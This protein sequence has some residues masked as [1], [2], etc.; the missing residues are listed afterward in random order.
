MTGPSYHPEIA[1]DTNIGIPDALPNNVFAREAWKKHYPLILSGLMLLIMMVSGCSREEPEVD[2]EAEGIVAKVG[3]FR[4]SDDHFR[5]ELMRFYYRTGQELNLNSQVRRSVVD[6]RVDRYAVVEYAREMDWHEDAEARY[7]LEKIKRK[8]NM[9]EFERRFIHDQ[10]SVNEHDL[11][12]LFNRMNTSVRASHLFVTYR[13]KAD[14][15]YQR[16]QKGASFDELAGELFRNPE[17]AENGGDIGYFTVDDMDIA[18]EDRA[19]RMEIGQISEP[20][21]TSR[22]YSI[23]KVTDRITTPVVTENQY[24]EKRDRIYPV[25]LDQKKE[26]ATRTHMDKII[27]SFDFDDNVIETM[28]DRF[29]QNRSRLTTD[30]PSEE[31]FLALL[32]GEKNNRLIIDEEDFQLSESDFWQEFYY[33][34]SEDRKKIDEFG[35]FRQLVE[36]VAYRA[37]ALELVESHPGYDEELVERTTE[38]TFYNYLIDRF[39]R[40]L[41]QRVEITGQQLVDEFHSNSELYMDPLE[42]NLSEII[43]ASEEKAGEA[44][45]KIRLGEN[46][47]NVLREYTIDREA[48]EY[49]GELG[50]IPIDKFGTM[51][52]YLGDIEPGETA[53]PFQLSSNRYVIFKCNGRREARP[54]TFEEAKPRVRQYL[55]SA[56]KEQLREEIVKDARTR[57]HAEIYTDRLNSLPIEL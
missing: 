52:T 53:G 16:L 48:V 45:E 44:R 23:I 56:E 38:E 12:T 22:G 47:S 7:Q 14:S 30:N 54:V 15:V 37:Y 55:Q 31:T 13:S 28:W 11:R 43:V 20:V 5:N 50:Y 8:V 3:E 26:L 39:D 51:S 41:D 34:P 40:Y 19:Y 21:K 36:G 1:N 46:F 49:D 2:P 17:L 25:A 6:S 42:L 57:Y 9:E 24:A 32:D 35:R 29:L 10:V 4:I 27:G 18:F 33:T